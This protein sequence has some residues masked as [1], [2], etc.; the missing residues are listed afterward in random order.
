M[1]SSG[2]NVW[3]AQDAEAGCRSEFWERVALASSWGGGQEQIEG[4]K[5]YS[6]QGER[7]ACMSGLFL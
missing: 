6:P 1:R 3:W 4:E 5:D 2:A 7:V